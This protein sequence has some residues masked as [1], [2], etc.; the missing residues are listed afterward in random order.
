M[1]KKGAKLPSMQGPIVLC[2][3]G[4]AFGTWMMPN[5]THSNK[6]FHHG[7]L[8]HGLTSL[9]IGLSGPQIR[10][11]N[12]KLFSYFSTKT[13]VVGTQNNRLNETVLSSTQNTYLN[14]WIR[15]SSHFYADFFCLTGPMVCTSPTISAS[16]RDLGSYCIVSQQNE[17]FSW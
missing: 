11:C 3:L 17:P 13:H 14:L 1:I 7:D 9:S 15:K 12:W 16:S 5:Y 6:T 2:N 8:L 4:Q 10:V